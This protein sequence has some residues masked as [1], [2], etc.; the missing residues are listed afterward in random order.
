LSDLLKQIGVTAEAL[1]GEAYFVG[2]CVRDMLR[3][4]PNKDVDIS[5]TGDTFELG[6]TI[7]NRHK[8]HVFWLHQDEQV[9]RV[10]LPRHD[11]LQLDLNPLRGTLEQDL[12][13][14]DLT[15]NAL[16]AP[17]A[18]GL[19]PSSQVLDV[20]GGVEDLR[21]GLIRFVSPEAPVTDPL[22]T[23]RAFRFRWKLDYRMAEGTEGLIRECVPLLARVSVERIRDELFQV[24]SITHAHEALAEITRVGTGP[25]L[26]GQQGLTFE[27]M[28]PR[29]GEVA[30]RISD[31]TG[32]LAELLVTEPTPGRR[33]RE[34]LLWAAAIQPLGIDASAA[35]RHLALSNDERQIVTKG[36]GA[37][38]EAQDLADRSPVA[39]RERY[40]LFK[41]AGGASPE[42]VLLAPGEWRAPHEELL[43]EALRRH[44]YPEPPLLTGQ[45]VMRI[46]D[47]KQGPALGRWMRELE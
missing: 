39:G 5:V 41:K 17:A 43:M 15:I 32:E 13:A 1:C 28:A 30:A 11:G 6:R 16:A 29:L 36:L 21:A 46:L 12:R 37:A 23:R 7:A 25:W 45:D 20:T 2:G 22:R 47:L 18:G 35:C 14:R 31:R 10:V 4:V 40:R 27:R 3:G 38:S 19:D 33:R 44:F 9:V 34:L 42:A 8:G 24:L 26:L